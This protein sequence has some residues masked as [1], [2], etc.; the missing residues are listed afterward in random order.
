MN[1][2]LLEHFNLKYKPFC[3]IFLSKSGCPSMYV[4]CA[5]RKASLYNL[6]FLPCLLYSIP[7]QYPEYLDQ[8]RRSFCRAEQT[9]KRNNH[10]LLLFIQ[11]T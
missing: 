5:R 2:L 8:V 7:A 4:S 1:K 9:F 3:P 10:K 11:V 6:L